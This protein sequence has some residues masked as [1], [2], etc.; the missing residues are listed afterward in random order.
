MAQDV[1]KQAGRTSARGVRD[2]PGR[3]QAG[4]TRTSSVP[5]MDGGW[6]CLHIFRVKRTRPAWVGEI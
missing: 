6:C 1:G 3:G 2:G 4:R 5:T